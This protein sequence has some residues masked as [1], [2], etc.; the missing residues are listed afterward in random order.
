[1][2]KLAH[3]EIKSKRKNLT[4]IKKHKRFPVVVLCD[5]IRSIYNVGSIFRTSDGAFIEKLYLCGYTPH[6]PRKEIDKVALGATLSVPYE[7]YKNPIEALEKIKE[8]GYK[9]CAL[10]Q[11]DRSIDYK[12]IKI[13]DFPLCLVIG[14]EISGVSNEIIERCEMSIEIPMYGVK[15]SL[16]VSVSYGIAIFELISKLTH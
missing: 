9:L 6:P 2:R 12:E 4:D 8:M 7:Y 1:M 13:E 14:N 15:Q 5:N 16:N 3:E 11:T 10:E